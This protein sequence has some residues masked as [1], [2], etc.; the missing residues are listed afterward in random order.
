MTTL[1]V[2]VSG[3][4][5]NLALRIEDDQLPEGAFVVVLSDESAQRIAKG[6]FDT[7]K[8]LKELRKGE[9]A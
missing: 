3:E 9:A 2:G 7:L 8:R 6:I 4:E 1:T 5:K